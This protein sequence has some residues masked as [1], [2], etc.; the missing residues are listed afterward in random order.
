ML[1]VKTCACTYMCVCV[2]VPNLHVSLKEHLPKREFDKMESGRGLVDGVIMTGVLVM[3]NNVYIIEIVSEGREGGRGGE[4]ERER[5]R[6]G[7][8]KREREREE[9]ETVFDT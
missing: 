7:E 3:R 9:V 5:V 4:R 6:E 8:K 1:D 2:H